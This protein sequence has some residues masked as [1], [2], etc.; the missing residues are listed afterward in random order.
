MGVRIPSGAPAFST[1]ACSGISDTPITRYFPDTFRCHFPDAVP[2]EGVSDVRAA[3]LPLQIVR[4]GRRELA[5]LSCCLGPRSRPAYRCRRTYLHL[6]NSTTIARSR[7]LHQ[8]LAIIFKTH[9]CAGRI[10]F[11]SLKNERV[12][13]MVYPARTK[14]KEDI[15]RYTELFYINDEFTLYNQ[16][17]I[18]SAVGYRTPAKSAP[19]TEFAARSIKGRKIQQSGKRGAVQ[20]YDEDR[21]PVRT[22]TAPQAMATLRNTAINLH[23]LAGATNIAEACRTDALTT[24]TA[25]VALL[26]N[27]QNPS[28]QAC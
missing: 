14:A 13:H 20:T 4:F 9:Q 5:W 8:N 26:G 22:G 12:H 1:N 3:G 2:I 15:A 21:S 19:S 25:A 27:P 7:L 18:R 10:V 6:P 11:A 23:R 17:R 24:T 16:R 28:P